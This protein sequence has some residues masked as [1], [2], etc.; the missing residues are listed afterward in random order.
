MTP[1]MITAAA[2]IIPAIT[3]V[4]PAAAIITAVADLPVDLAVAGYGG[5][6]F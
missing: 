2:V 5:S 1:I 4:T 3:A 6:L